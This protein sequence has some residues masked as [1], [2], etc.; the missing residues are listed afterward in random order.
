MLKKLT[1]SYTLALIGLVV[2]LGSCTREY[3]SIETTDD[4]KIQQYI[5][6]NNLDVVKDSTG[7][8]YQIVTQGTG[9]NFKNTDSV[10]YHTN[11]KSLL[12]GTTYY[13]DPAN[14]NFGTL[15]GYANNFNGSNIP[16]I[17][18][19]ILALKPGG[20]VRIL[21]PSYLAFGK[22]GFSTI[23]IPSNEV[24]DLTI[25]TEPEKTQTALDDRRIREFIAAKGIAGMTKGPGGIYYVIN[26]PGTAGSPINAGSVVSV[27]YTGKLLDGSAFDSAT[28]VDSVAI[29]LADPG[30]RT[31]WKK[32]IPMIN[33][34][35]KVRFLSPSIEAY[36]STGATGKEGF[37]S[38]PPNAVLDFDVEVTDVK[39]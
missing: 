25:S 1:V 22:N 3:D 12:N 16:A 39:N 37:S 8:Y 21:L 17:R 13:T 38:I 19:S 15:V 23:N 20:T 36:G 5:R 31:S 6:A 27:N 10:L 30:V 34:G 33:K 11:L 28:L 35:G 2:F 32:I 7:F 9:E 4:A 29:P 26:A 24:I 18:T 14:G